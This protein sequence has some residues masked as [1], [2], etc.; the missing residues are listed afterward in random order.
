[1]KTSLNTR[2]TTAGFTLAELL[3]SL[4][5]LGVV[6][7]FTIPS[8]LNAQQTGSYNAKAKQ[9]IAMFQAAY[10]SYQIDHQ[11]TAATTSWDLTPYMNYVSVDTSTTIDDVYGSTSYGCDSGGGH[12]CLFLQNGGRIVLPQSGFGNTASTNCIYMGFDPDGTYGGT[13]NGPGKAIGVYLYYDGMV[14]DEDHAKPHS[15]S[16]WWVN[17]GPG[18]NTDPPWFSWSQ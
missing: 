9:T 14:Y 16:S 8:V 5:V 13:T 10:N 12:P 1:M 4:V 7:A 3:I 11:P 18:T 15:Y 6:A 17:F 2:I